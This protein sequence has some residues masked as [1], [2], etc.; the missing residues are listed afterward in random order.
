MLA[1]HCSRNVATCLHLQALTTLPTCMSCRPMMALMS[2]ALE[3]CAHALRTCVPSYTDKSDRLFFMLEAHSP[4]QTTRRGS[5]GAHL[6]RETRFRVTGHVAA[7][8]STS[9]GKRGLE[10]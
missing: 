9:I 2:D 3:T 4:Q 10:P 8:E 6:S 7:Q 5:A 1:L